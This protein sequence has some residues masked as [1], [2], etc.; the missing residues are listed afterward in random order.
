VNFEG[1]VQRARRATFPP[2]QAKEDWAILR[3]LSDVVGKRL[4]YDTLDGVRAAIYAVAPHFADHGEA[5]PHGGAG[6]TN[7]NAVGANVPLDINT[8]LGSAM[9]DF[10]LTNPI[11]RA[12]ATMAQ[13]SREF[14][15]GAQTLAAE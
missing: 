13:C 3:A 7:W 5:V 4:P 10:Y 11:A 6:T 12:S 2:G 15:T 14:V 8:K 9:S 1:R